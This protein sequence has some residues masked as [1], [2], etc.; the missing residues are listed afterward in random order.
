[1]GSPKA[2]STLGENDRS[3]LLH[4]SITALFT[5]LGLYLTAADTG[6]AQIVQLC[7]LGEALAALCQHSALAPKKCCKL[8]QEESKCAVAFTLRL[9]E[10]RTSSQYSPMCAVKV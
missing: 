7:C 2:P 8:S 4:V 9:I 10:V 5:K 3:S 1:M 6:P